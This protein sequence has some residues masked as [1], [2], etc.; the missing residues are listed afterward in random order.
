VKYYVNGKAV[1]E[2]TENEK[3]TEAKRFLKTKEGKA[4]TGKPRAGSGK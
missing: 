2:S 3:G 4:A 1:Y